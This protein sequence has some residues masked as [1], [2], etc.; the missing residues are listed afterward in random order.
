MDKVSLGRLASP[1]PMGLSL[2]ARYIKLTYRGLTRWI[3]GLELDIRND[4]LVLKR[5]HRLDETRKSRRAFTM[6]QVR[7]HLR[8][9]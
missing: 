8:P 7:F 1:F 4:C 3:G 9:W 5:D 6:T 2:L